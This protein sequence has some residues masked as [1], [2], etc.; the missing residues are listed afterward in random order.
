MVPMMLVSPSDWKP[1][2]WL[3]MLLGYA[4]LGPRELDC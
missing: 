3:G 4:P 2:G 1:N